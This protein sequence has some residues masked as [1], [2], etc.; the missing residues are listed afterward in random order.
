MNQTELLQIIDSAIVRYRGDVR[1]LQTAIGALHLGLA[2]G[3][4]PLRLVHSHRTFVRYQEILQLDFHEVLPEVGVKADKLLAWRV[5]KVAK[6]FWD[7]ARGSQPGRSR[8]YG[9]T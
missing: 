6:N 7:V 9:I 2:V 8:E 1:V 4:K 3:W 5:A